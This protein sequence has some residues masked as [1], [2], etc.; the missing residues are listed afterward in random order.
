[1]SQLAFDEPIPQPP[2]P[3]TPRPPR[4]LSWRFHRNND[5][6]PIE[7]RQ[8]V[9]QCECQAPLEIHERIAPYGWIV[10]YKINRREHNDECVL[11]N[12]TRANREAHRRIARAN[13]NEAA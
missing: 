1:M 9:V 10:I 8:H 2:P 12:P 7:I 5:D 4:D 3:R 11:R 6:P 13:G